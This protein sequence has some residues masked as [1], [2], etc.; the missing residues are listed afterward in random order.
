MEVLRDL[1]QGTLTFNRMDDVN[2]RKS[3]HPHNSAISGCSSDSRTILVGNIYRIKAYL[4]CPKYP[5][6]APETKKLNV[7]CFMH[8]FQKYPRF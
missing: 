5:N 6:S 7:A 2:R 8:I 4:K 3:L 1:Q